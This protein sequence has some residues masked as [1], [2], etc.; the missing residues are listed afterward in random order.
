MTIKSNSNRVA[1]KLIAAI[2]A[3]SMMGTT[4][5]PALAFHRGAEDEPNVFECL[6]LLITDPELHVEHCGVGDRSGAGLDWGST[7]TAPEDDPE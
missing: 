7:G 6:G 4:I 2:T 1:P 5:S 3:V